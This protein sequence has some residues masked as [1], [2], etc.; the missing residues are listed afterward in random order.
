MWAMKS[1]MPGFRMRVE[2][3]DPGRVLVVRSGNHAWA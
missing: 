2:R 3:L 1:P